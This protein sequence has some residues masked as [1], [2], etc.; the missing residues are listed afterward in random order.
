MAVQSSEFAGSGAASRLVT[1]THATPSRPAPCSH[2]GPVPPDFLSSLCLGGTG[3][4]GR[5]AAGLPITAGMGS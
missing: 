2:H 5:L 4:T 3:H 1:P